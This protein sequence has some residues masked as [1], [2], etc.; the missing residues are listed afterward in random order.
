V[1]IWNLY[2]HYNIFLLTYLKYDR[3]FR[4]V[5]ECMKICYEQVFLGNINI[6]TKYENVDLYR[7]ENDFSI[8]RFGYIEKEFEVYRRDVILVKI[9][10]GAYVEL[11]KINNFFDEL[12]IRL[13]FTLDGFIRIRNDGIVMVT[14]LFFFGHKYVD[15]GSL[16]PC[17]QNR[18]EEKVSHKVLK[19]KIYKIYSVYIILFDWYILNWLLLVY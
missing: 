1:N 5:D 14:F 4:Q 10:D 11:E 2:N 15:E 3:I 9:K 12:K 8:E 17:F 7:F 16:I 13:H 6:C 18:N 19:R